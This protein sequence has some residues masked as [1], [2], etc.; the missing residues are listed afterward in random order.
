MIKKK[1][2]QQMRE[3]LLTYKKELLI[4]ASQVPDIDIDGDETDEIQGNLL[5]ELANQLSSRDM[6]KINQINDA[7]RRIDNNS[8]GVCED[9]EDGI[10]EK[11][12]L[13][14][15]Y[16]LTCV[17]CAEERETEEKQRKRS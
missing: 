6:I 4:R 9:C 15:P 13:A 17:I 16:F 1:F 2:L 8:Y 7:L 14:N 5:I 10:P 11:R 3:N 12:L